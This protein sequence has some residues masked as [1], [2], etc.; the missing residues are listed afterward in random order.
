[1]DNAEETAT[2]APQG[3]ADV[4]NEAPDTSSG[5]T[6]QNDAAGVEQPETQQGQSQDAEGELIL[7]KFKSQADLEKAYRALESHSKKTEMER[8]EMEK[9]FASNKTGESNSAPAESSQLSD[10]AKEVL[11]K[12]GPEITNELVKQISPK[13]AELTS[14]YEVNLM[15]DKYG[16]G[17]TSNAKAIK[18]LQTERPYLSLEDA[19]KIVAHDTLQR[20]SYN[21]GVSKGAETAEQKQKAQVESSRPSGFRPTSPE[22]ALGSAKSSEEM[23]QVFEALGPEFKKFA[24][25]SKNRSRKI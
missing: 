21:Q 24:E 16:D 7:G 8:A 11:A 2:T 14:K 17:F 10:T 5:E 18:E 6:P 23:A 19:Y 22:E 13:F 9:L 25:T 1:M 12:M 20:T 3:Q 4:V 15:V